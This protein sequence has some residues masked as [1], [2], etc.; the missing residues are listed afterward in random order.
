MYYVEFQGTFVFIF[1]EC[2]HN[3]IHNNEE[4][5]NI[6]AAAQTLPDELLTNIFSLLGPRDLCRCA[7]VSRHWN[8]AAFSGQLWKTLHLSR[9]GLADW[10]FGDEL[11]SDDCN[12]DCE[13]NYELMTFIA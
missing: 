10:R 8:Q 4:D 5:S 7:Q 6:I 9:W 3:K 11:S 13:P 1:I 12:C 2:S